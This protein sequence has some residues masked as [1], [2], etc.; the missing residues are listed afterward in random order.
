MLTVLK[1]TLYML[2]N[3]RLPANSKL[4]YFV[5]YGGIFERGS[6]EYTLDDFYSL[7]LEKLDRFQCLKQS[8][9]IIEDKE[10]SSESSDDDEDDEDD[11]DSDS[12]TS[13]FEGNTDG[14]DKNGPRSKHSEEGEVDVDL[15]LP[16]EQE[17]LGLPEV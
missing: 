14:K 17:E 9:I 2:V 4:R 3:R 8:N 6:R 16:G 7:N 13:E 12:E 15:E 10:S 5:S 11:D 1:N